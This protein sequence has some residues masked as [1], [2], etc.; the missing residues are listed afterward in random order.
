MT[1]ITFEYFSIF[2]P[3]RFFKLLTE[4]YMIYTYSLG[5][6]TDLLTHSLICPHNALKTHI[7]FF[8]AKTIDHP[9]NALPPPPN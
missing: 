8:I 9:H 7:P 1:L 4:A 2:I 5:L 3:Q 6:L